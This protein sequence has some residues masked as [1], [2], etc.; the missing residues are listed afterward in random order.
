MGLKSFSSVGRLLLIIIG[1][2]WAQEDSLRSA[3]NA[4]DRRQKDLDFSKYDDENLG[5][6]GYSLEGPDD[7]AFLSPSDYTTGIY[8]FNKISFGKLKL[9]F[10]NVTNP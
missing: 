4:I 10:A 5:E 3:L 8:I 2:T 1:L 7:L 6:Y 9:S